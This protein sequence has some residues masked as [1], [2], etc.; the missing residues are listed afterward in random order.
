MVAEALLRI[1]LDDIRV[2]GSHTCGLLA[3]W[4]Q[5]CAAKTTADRFDLF[6]S[7]RLM[8]VAIVSLGVSG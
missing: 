8:N 3:V 2:V 6:R 4:F 1:C 5:M 7:Q